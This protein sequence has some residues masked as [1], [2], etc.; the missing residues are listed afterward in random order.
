MNEKISSA[1]DGLKDM[2]E[3]MHIK[4]TIS[5]VGDK[6]KETVG[7]IDIQETIGDVADKYKSGG[8]K[9][10]VNEIG[11]TVKDVAGKASEAVKNSLRE[12]PGAAVNAADN[13]KVTPKLVKEDTASLNNNPRNNDM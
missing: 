10:A 7:E 12:N 6:V 11:E 9:G 8:I 2:A 13:G 1:F 3:N 4:E 5:R